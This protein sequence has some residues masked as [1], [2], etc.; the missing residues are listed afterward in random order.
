MMSTALKA[1]HP[2]T[3]TLNLVSEE[4]Q[5][6]IAGEFGRVFSDLN[7]GMSQK[8]ALQAMLIRMPSMSLHT[9]ITAVIIQ[10]ETGGALAEIIENVA[11]VIR[12]RFKLQRKIKS[13]S[14]EGRM[15]AWVLA[16]IPFALALLLMVAS[17]DYLPVFCLLYTS[18][19]PRDGLLSRMPSSA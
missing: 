3:E 12:G 13:L 6:P 4:M 1:G 19:S 14:A 10:T 7:F 8:A 15:S 16:L 17:P 18:P 11:D 9:L 2:F 5:D